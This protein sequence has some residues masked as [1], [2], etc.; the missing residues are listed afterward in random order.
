MHDVTFLDQNVQ[1]HRKK[2]LTLTSLCLG[3]H[4]LSNNLTGHISIESL[5]PDH[6]RTD[7]RNPECLYYNM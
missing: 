6:H 4:F 7:V 3:K 1:C 5:W 2:E